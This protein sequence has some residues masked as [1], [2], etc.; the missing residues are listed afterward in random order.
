MTTS[1]KRVKIIGRLSTERYMHGD[2][3]VCRHKFK[4]L[5]R[6]SQG[7]LRDLICDPYYDIAQIDFGKYEDGIYELDMV[8]QSIDVESGVLDDWELTLKPIN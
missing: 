5:K 8:V 1:D 2:E 4:V 6:K 7:S 3:L